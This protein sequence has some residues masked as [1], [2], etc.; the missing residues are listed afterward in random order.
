M[1]RRE[2]VGELLRSARHQKGESLRSAAVG[3]DVDPSYLSRVESGEK[4]PSDAF[5][6]AAS[7]YYGLS[8]DQVHL[9]AGDVPDDIIRLLQRNPQLIDELR[10]RY[11]EQ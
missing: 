10:S 2:M 3:L 4:P 8:R 11:G 1:K 6:R 9:A 7:D 5:Q